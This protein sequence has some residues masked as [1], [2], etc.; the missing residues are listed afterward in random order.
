MFPFSSIKI[1]LFGLIM[2][3]IIMLSHAG[4]SNSEIEPGDETGGGTK[5]EESGSGTKPGEPV[6]R[7]RVV[8]FNVESADGAPVD[9]DGLADTDTPA[10]GEVDKKLKGKVKLADLRKAIHE[11]ED[12]ETL[13]KFHKL[14]EAELNRVKYEMEEIVK[15]NPV[16]KDCLIENRVILDKYL[17]ELADDVQRNEKKINKKWF[18]CIPISRIRGKKRDELKKKLNEYKVTCK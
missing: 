12:L 3:A 5:P 17:K 14:G 9:I 15:I 10:A 1:T 2:M 8:R 7:K 11:S 6:G 4:E 16:L 13:N 18:H